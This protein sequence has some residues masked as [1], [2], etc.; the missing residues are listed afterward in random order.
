[1]LGCVILYGLSLVF[2]DMIFPAW[3]KFF[4]TLDPL[5][6]TRTSKREILFLKFISIKPQSVN[7]GL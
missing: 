4:I 7:G 5:S 1:M 2:T 6:N 3:L